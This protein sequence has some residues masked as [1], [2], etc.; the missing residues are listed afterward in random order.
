MVKPETKF[1][2]GQKLEMP[3]SSWTAEKDV[4]VGYSNQG[5]DGKV[6]VFT[7]DTGT[8]G[9]NLGAMIRGDD[10]TPNN[11]STGHV[12]QILSGGNF[13]VTDVQETP[14]ATIVSVKQTEFFAK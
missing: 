2:V 9:A 3:I 5:T 8:V 6:V 10:A 11:S 4:A 14:N 7:A 1:T 13:K 12:D